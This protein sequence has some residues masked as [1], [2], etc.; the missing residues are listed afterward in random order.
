MDAVETAGTSAIAFISGQSYRQLL[1]FFYVSILFLRCWW[2]YACSYGSDV[3]HTATNTHDSSW[4]WITKASSLFCCG[5]ITHHINY[6][7]RFTPDSNTE[8][9]LCDATTLLPTPNLPLS[10][11]IN[12]VVHSNANV[13]NTGDRMYAKVLAVSSANI[14]Q[15]T[16]PFPVILKV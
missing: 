4:C 5:M 13:I 8:L 1:H 15:R 7:L 9:A 14:R 16:L 2:Q 3:L 10:C 12:G 11:H 6:F